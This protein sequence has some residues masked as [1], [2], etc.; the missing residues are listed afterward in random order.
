[1]Y[2]V[3]TYNNDDLLKEQSGGPTLHDT[4]VLATEQHQAILADQY[5]FTVIRDDGDIIWLI[6]CEGVIYIADDAELNAGILN[7]FL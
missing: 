3:M 1:M 2:T 6:N 7:M 4:V 5:C